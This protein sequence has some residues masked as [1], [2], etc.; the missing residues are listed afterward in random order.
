MSLS[1]AATLLKYV[2]G[3][4]ATGSVL[5]AGGLWYFQRHLIYPSNL[6]SGSRTDVPTPAQIGLP[7]EDITLTTNDHLKLHAYLIP[8][9]RRPV[10]LQDLQSLSNEDRKARMKAEVDGWVE[11]MGKEDAVEYI[12]S[13]PTVVFFHA[14]AGNMGHRLPLARKFNVEHGCNVFML[15]YRGYGKSEGHASELGMRIDV[16]AALQYI[17]A[18]PL[19]GKTKLIVYGQSIG[20]A[21][22]L[23]AAAS[24]PDMISGIIIENTFLSL[25]LLI[26]SIMPQIPRFLLPILL[27]E[28]W[29]AALSLPK[30]RKSTPILMLSGK[31]DELV[32]PSHMVE[33]RRIREGGRVQEASWQEEGQ[34]ANAAREKKDLGGKVRWREFPSGTHNDTCLIPGYWKEIGEWIREEVEGLPV[35]KGE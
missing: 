20:G 24:H 12:K 8:A 13:R 21:V 11:E 1:S 32:P 25:P 28:Q 33:L 15:S 3:T 30:I 5:V 9:R 18:H 14:N 16:E 10:T 6:P 19:I 29:D 17:Q 31:K 7:Y 23:Y 26:P 35:E 4:A 2:A 34:A 27:T 22:S